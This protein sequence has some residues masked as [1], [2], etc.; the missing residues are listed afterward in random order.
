MRKHLIFLLVALSSTLVS[1][2]APTATR[3]SPEELTERRSRL[4]TALGPNALFVALPARTF[5]RNG[6]VDFAYRQHDD[7]LYL[8]GV[9]APDTALTIVPGETVHR[10]TLFTRNRD[11][12]REVWTGRIDSFEV[13]RERTGIKSI[14][15]YPQLKAFIDA[16]LTGGSWGDARQYRTYRQPAMLAFR[17][18][19]NEGR[20][21]IWLLLGARP[22]ARE[23]ATPE[24]LF[25]EELKRRYPEIRIRNASR[26]VHDM[27]EL[28]SPSEVAL[29]TRAIDITVEAHK[30]AMRRVKSANHEY[31]LEATIEYTFRNLGACCYGFPSIVASGRNATT[32]HYD[33]NNDPIERE[34]LLLADIGAEVEGYT[35]DVTR[36]FPAD[37]TF[38]P[39]QRTIY[40]AVLAAQEQSIALMTVGKS[41][42]DVHEKAQEILGR[43]LLD[44]GLI[45]R[46]ELDQVRLYFLH[47][48]GHHV[49]LD[50][51]DV[52]DR[53]RK[54]EAGMALTNEPGIYVRKNDVLANA[55]YLKLSESDRKTIAAALDRYDG[56]G[57]R[58]ED[59]IL[60]TNGA[61][62]LLSGGAP[63]TVAE[64][65]AWMK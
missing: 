49:G 39:E 36:T 61:P 16:A 35:A 21:E 13:M 18:A 15:A 1:V 57:V 54:F 6:D 41:F 63:R 2:A 48:I 3:V 44:L 58:I 12:L 43:T 7:I 10:E 14:Y 55:T 27:R 40:E 8:T 19:M 22:H 26:L 56:I 33:T 52:S 11:P 9:E 5:N 46:N 38:S 45:T 17:E 47:G 37:G 20:A 24:M 23:D 53:T 30:A 29:L 59:D 32:L 50:V 4:A 62:R 34:G 51:H 64:I 31:E 42:S 65:E 28:K 60:V 25:A